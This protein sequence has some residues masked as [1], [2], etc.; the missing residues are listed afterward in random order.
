M[1]TQPQEKYYII[2]IDNPNERLAFQF[3]PQEIKHNAT[4]KNQSVEIVGRSNPQIHY[5]GGDDKVSFTLNFHAKKEDISYVTEQCRW[6]QSLRGKDIK[7]IFGNLYQNTVF[8]LDNAN[9]TYSNFNVEFDYHEIAS[10][11]VSFT[12]NPIRSLN[13]TD[14]RNGE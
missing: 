6:L 14:I 13:S 5:T 1:K 8:A 12:K 10:V 11:E 2:D 7:L 9:I 4:A 3:I